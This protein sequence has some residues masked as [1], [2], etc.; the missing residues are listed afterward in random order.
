MSD[1]RQVTMMYAT[2]VYVECPHC[3]KRQDGF[4]GNPAGGE[5][6]CEVCKNIYTI[7]PDA[8]IEHC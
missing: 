6:T 7:H 2:E 1:E 5:F 4:L 3:L 8:D